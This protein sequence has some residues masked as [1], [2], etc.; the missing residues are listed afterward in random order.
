VDARAT[1]TSPPRCASNTLP[2][3]P[4]CFRIT[5]QRL[6]GENS[7][8]QVIGVITEAPFFTVKNGASV[9]LFSGAAFGLTTARL[10]R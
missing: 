2:P 7:V 4:F 10:R 1:P 8:P 9:V 6:T 5:P 3:A